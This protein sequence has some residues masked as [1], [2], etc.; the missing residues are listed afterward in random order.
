MNVIRLELTEQEA[1]I[2]DEVME[3]VDETAAFLAGLSHE[4]RLDWLKE[5][6]Y[7][8]PISFEREIGGTVYTVKAHFSGDTAESVEDKVIRILNRNIAR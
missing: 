2:Y 4:E 7:S 8:H 5:H 1:K 6:Q 3:K